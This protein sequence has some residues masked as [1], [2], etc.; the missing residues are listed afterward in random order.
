MQ[1]PEALGGLSHS[2]GVDHNENEPDGAFIPP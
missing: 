1:Q 2:G